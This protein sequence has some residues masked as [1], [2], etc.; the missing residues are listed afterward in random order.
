MAGKQINLC[1]AVIDGHLKRKYNK[2]LFSVGLPILKL[3]VSKVNKYTFQLKGPS[4][5]HDRPPDEENYENNYKMYSVLC[6]WNV[7][8]KHFELNF[9]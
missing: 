5:N 4:W 2:A 7:S 6:Q 3:C 1:E 8:A 9:M